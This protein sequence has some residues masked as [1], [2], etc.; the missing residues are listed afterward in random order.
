MNEIQM[1][2]ILKLQAES[3]TLK[4][5]N[6]INKVAIENY[7]KQLKELEL[8]KGEG[9]RGDGHDRGLGMVMLLTE[10]IKLMFQLPVN[11][12]VAVNGVGVAFLNVV[13]E[14]GVRFQMR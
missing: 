4:Q 13:L 7:K 9:R 8:N 3:T 10:T 5:E 6:E 2:K 1:A 14:I 12:H 11:V